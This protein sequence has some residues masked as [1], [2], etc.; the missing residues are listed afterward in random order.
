M[1]VSNH[2]SR[3]AGAFALA[4]GI[5]GLAAWLGGIAA[6]TTILPGFP[7]MS[8]YTALS[9]VFSGFALWLLK[10]PT[11]SLAT[12][13]MT[14]LSSLVPTAIGLVSI[15]SYV[16]QIDLDHTWIKST[17]RNLQVTAPS[18][19]TA[20]CLVSIGLGLLVV[21]SAKH[22]SIAQ[23]FATCS[24]AISLTALLGYAYGVPVLY[25]VTAS[26]GM[27]VHTAVTLIVLSLGIL[28]VQPY[29]GLMRPLRPDSVGRN[30]AG[31][32]L[33]TIVIVPAAFGWLR[34]KGER[35]GLYGAEVGVALLVVLTILALVAITM[36]TAELLNR[37]QNQ[38][39]AVAESANDAV[40]LANHKGRITYFNQAAERLFQYPSRE[41]IQESLTI[42]MPERFRA[43]HEQG[44]KR[45]LATR[46]SR[47]IGTTIEL[48]GRTK[49]GIE[50]PI[51]L[52]LSSWQGSLGP[53][54][55]GTIRDISQRKQAEE[56]LLLQTRQLEASKGE[57]RL[58]QS[59]AR[60]KKAFESSPISLTISTQ[61]E[62]IYL[63]VNQAFLTL[64]GFQREEMIGKSAYELNIWVL[65]RQ[66]MEMVERLTRDGRVEEF[67]TE[68]MTKS[69]EHKI[70]EV[71]AELIVIDDTPCVL[72]MTRDVTE[73]QHLEKQLRQAQ[74]MEAI[75]RLAGGVAH[76]FNN[77]LGVIMGYSDLALE[78]C[79][80]DAT[81]TKKIEQ[82]KK[83]GDRAAALTRQLLAFS[84]QQILQPTVLNLNAVVNHVSG[85]LVRMIGEDISLRFSPGI[86]LDNI[87]A[88]LGQIE[89]I[90]MNLVVNAR[91]AMP[92]GGKILIE[93]ANAELDEVFAQKHTTVRPGHYVLLA[94]TDTGQGMDADT[95]SHAF[96]PFFTTK[97][98]GKGTGLG[99]ST[100]HGIVKQ[101][102]GHIWIYSERGKG[103]TF[104]IYFPQVQQPAE[105]LI[106]VSDEELPRGSE[107]ILVVEDDADLRELTCDL[108]RSGG[109]QTIEAA[110]ANEALR[111]AEQSE[112]LDLLLT[113]VIMPGM[114]GAELAKMVGKLKPNLKILY[115]SGYTSSL[116]EH[117]E[118]LESGSQLLQ[119]P[120][121]KKSLLMRV[122]S[123][124]DTR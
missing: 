40:V 123:T 79:R 72:A 12:K 29:Q 96:E 114:N 119:K 70:V 34:L 3:A 55:T 1:A 11:P 106:S 28:F 88:D 42:L 95:L 89:Q 53:C 122:R 81:L 2:V 91:D 94:V 111:V 63:D 35:S 22:P 52:S 97:P 49:H 84:R 67:E 78:H 109:Y 46:T 6:L 20:I 77:L 33:P 7:S 10:S 73:A 9:L 23:I 68:M 107:T 118:V 13:I 105:T 4:M 57:L 37:S 61:K 62:G 116:I 120:F 50:F 76:D 30:L 112:T 24:L 38:F 25:A 124:I 14:G 103:T 100:V 48:V 85:M 90:L 69:G 108:L 93:T 17:A 59:E 58:K 74:K 15:T 39:R 26:V 104:R 65:P 43:A 36:V 71:S 115:M 117:H 56:K 8:F 101:S 92:E 21:Q 66:R 54:F 45:F 83:A 32:M 27:A 113:D 80:A 18:P 31:W 87:K 86:P 98:Q 99:L 19:Q 44:L 5:F 82:I 110:S 64:M 51:E 41:A 60:F 47:I 121:T 16:L 102:D 75:G